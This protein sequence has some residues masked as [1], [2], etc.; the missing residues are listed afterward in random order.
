M[1]CIYAFHFIF[2]D[3]LKLNKRASIKGHFKNRPFFQR[4]ISSRVPQRILLPSAL[5]HIKGWI[6]TE[7]VQEKGEQWQ[8]D[9]LIT[10]IS[11]CAQ[12]NEGRARGCMIE[13]YPAPLNKARTTFSPASF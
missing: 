9:I 11:A 5:A 10:V 8:K 13:Q 4:A 7:G 6:R 1:A 2:K 3:G 12:A